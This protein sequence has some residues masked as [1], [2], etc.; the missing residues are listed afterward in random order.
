[1]KFWGKG[2]K[3][4]GKGVKFGVTGLISRAKLTKNG[5]IGL[6]LLTPL[7]L[8]Q[9]THRTKWVSQNLGAKGVIKF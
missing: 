9:L 7:D 1:M 4:W 8:T 2:V 5:A 6:T 3:F